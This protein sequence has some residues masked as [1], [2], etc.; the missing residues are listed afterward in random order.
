MSPRVREDSVHPRRQSGSCTRPLNFTVR[1]PLCTTRISVRVATTTA[2]LTRLTGVPRCLPL[3][4]WNTHTISLRV[5]SHLNWQ[6]HSTKWPRKLGRFTPNTTFGESTSAR[7]AGPRAVLRPG[8]YGHR[9]TYFC[10]AA[11]SFMYRP[12]EYLTTLRP[13]GTLPRRD[14]SIPSYLALNTARSSTRPPCAMLIPVRFRLC[15]LRR[16][17]ASDLKRGLGGCLTIARAAVIN[18]IRR[19]ASTERY[20]VLASLIRRPMT[21]AELHR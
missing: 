18:E 8:P 15:R 16:N 5:M 20:C 4:G 13:I 11:V 12:V 6:P 21:A 7:C 3:V 2:L 17:T 9:R 1:Q 14:T 19:D 10:Q